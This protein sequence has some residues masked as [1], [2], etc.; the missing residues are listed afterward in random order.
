MNT[1]NSLS[2]GPYVL[3]PLASRKSLKWT[4]SAQVCISDCAFL[5]KWGFKDKMIASLVEE[6]TI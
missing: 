4:Y 3:H 5:G 2:H 1:T 6:L